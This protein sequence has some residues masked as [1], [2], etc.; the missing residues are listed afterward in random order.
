MGVKDNF[1]YE[2][3]MKELNTMFTGQR[4]P[5]RSF[6]EYFD[7]QR[8][9]IVA[10]MQTGKNTELINAWREDF[11]KRQRE[12]KEKRYR[13]ELLECSEKGVEISPEC[14]VYFKKQF[15]TTSENDERKENSKRS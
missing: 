1:I 14:K 13:K 10:D 9:R 8:D 6:G 7:D 4:Q 12:K 15:E 5:K 11:D 2:E 3:C